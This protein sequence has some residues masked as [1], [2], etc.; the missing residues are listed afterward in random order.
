MRRKIQALPT[1]AVQFGML[2]HD[3]AIFNGLAIDHHDTQ[4]AYPLLM[5]LQTP[6]FASF[7]P[8]RDF[9]SKIAAFSGL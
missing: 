1:R 8:L 3:N 9:D 6:Y 5:L 7:K 4:R 2:R